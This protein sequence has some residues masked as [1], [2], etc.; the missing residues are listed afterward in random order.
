MSQSKNGL[1]VAALI[2]GIGSWVIL[3]LLAAVAAIILGSMGKK[4]ADQGLAN[5]RGMSQAG[6]ILGWI[7]VGITVFV[8]VLVLILFVAGV[9]V[10]NSTTY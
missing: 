5:N 8:G 3:P 7:N 9:L 6:S 10:I 4:A 1:G 2:C